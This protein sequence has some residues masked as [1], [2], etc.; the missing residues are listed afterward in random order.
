MPHNLGNLGPSIGGLDVLITAHLCHF[1]SQSPKI[2]WFP[3]NK[4]DSDLAIALLQMEH[5]QL[6][7]EVDFGPTRS[8]KRV[9]SLQSS[10]E[11]ER[12]FVK[13]ERHAPTFG[14][15]DLADTGFFRCGWQ[16]GDVGEW[17]GKFCC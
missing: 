14:R 6:L 13:R 11:S 15:D 2:E 7:E 17:V 16:S 10:L 1:L 12:G 9:E 4:R 8:L 3:I 5:G